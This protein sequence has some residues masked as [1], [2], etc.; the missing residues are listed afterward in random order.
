ML[1]MYGCEELLGATG[2]A[3]DLDGEVEVRAVGVAGA[4]ALHQGVTGSDSVAD[5]DGVAAGEAMAVRVLGSVISV[6]H[7]A[8]PAGPPG[9][10]RHDDTARSC[11]DLGSC[12]D[13]DIC[14]GV[15]V[16]GFGEPLGVLVVPPALDR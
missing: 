10:R 4:G 7:H 14:C 16:M 2:C 6:D 13:R 8:D 11:V 12:G 15:V 5:G 9:G 1:L 3:V